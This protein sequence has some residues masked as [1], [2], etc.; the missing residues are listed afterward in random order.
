MNLARHAGMVLLFALMVGCGKGGSVEKVGPTV[1]GQLLHNGKSISLRKDETITVSLTS[2]QGTGG[3]GE[4]AEDGS[5][6]IAGGGKG[7]GVAPGTYEVRVSS[8][9]YGGDG[10]DRFATMFP[11]SK[12]SSPLKPITVEIGA[13]EN[14]T[15]LIDIGKRTATKQ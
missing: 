10:E 14:Q 11:S 2:A 9:I 12:E 4:V 1:K 7:L 6:E 13:E 15:I 8:T 3:V 5:F